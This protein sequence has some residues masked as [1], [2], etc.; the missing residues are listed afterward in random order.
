MGQEEQNRGE[1]CH[2]RQEEQNRGERCHTGHERDRKNKT[3]VRD[4]TQDMNGTGGTKP[5]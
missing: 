5:R 2:T 4:V 1:R 3:E